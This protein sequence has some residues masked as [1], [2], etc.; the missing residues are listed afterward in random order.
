MDR[1]RARAIRPDAS[2]LRGDASREEW[3]PH[4][5]GPL[6]RG[7]LPAITSAVAL[8]IVS[9]MLFLWKVHMEEQIE[10]Q[11][12]QQLLEKIQRSLDDLHERIDHK[13]DDLHERID[14]MHNED[15]KS[16]V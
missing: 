2:H 1:P 8:L 3:C 14:H 10:A 9:T 13:I 5:Q 12:H 7:I 11:E 4:C 6:P 16:V 15:R